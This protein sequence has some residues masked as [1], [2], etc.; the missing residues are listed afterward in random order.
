MFWFYHK[1]PWW[2]QA[3]LFKMNKR[4]SAS[5]LKKVSFCRRPQHP[6]DYKAQIKPVTV[7]WHKRNIVFWKKMWRKGNMVK[8]FSI[9]RRVH[10]ADKDFLPLL[11]RRARTARPALEAMRDLKP[12]LFLRFLLLILIVIFIFYLN[13]QRSRI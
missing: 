10:Q 9:N 3:L 8:Y 6:W 11:L 2:Q 13:C 4:G 12:C 7:S 5:P 1:P